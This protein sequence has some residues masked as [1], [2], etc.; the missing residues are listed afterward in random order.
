MPLPTCKYLVS[1]DVK[2]KNHRPKNGATHAKSPE[3]KPRF[4]TSIN[5]TFNL[6]Q[7]LNLKQPV[8]KFLVNR[9]EVL[10][11]CPQRKKRQSA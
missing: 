4:Y 7:K 3:T 9:N 11:I 6:S 8:W 1:Y 2:E 10:S 5:Y